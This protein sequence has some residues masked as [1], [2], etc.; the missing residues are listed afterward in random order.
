M[1]LVRR[2]IILSE[3]NQEEVDASPRAADERACQGSNRYYLSI[4]LPLSPAEAAVL[5]VAEL[6]LLERHGQ[7]Q[8]RGDGRC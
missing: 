7:G 5:A 3:T 6:L 2:P 4:E 8:Q 1:Q